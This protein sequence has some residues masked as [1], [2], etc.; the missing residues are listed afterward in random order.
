MRPP[1]TPFRGRRRSFLQRQAGSR[2]SLLGEHFLGHEAHE[3]VPKA[4][5]GLSE[6]QQRDAALEA[7][8][9]LSRQWS[10]PGR[11]KSAGAIS[12]FEDD[13]EVEHGQ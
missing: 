3:H 1:I 5:A 7:A 10:R 4:P 11:A 2:G 8:R 13:A 6:K 12:R 9:S